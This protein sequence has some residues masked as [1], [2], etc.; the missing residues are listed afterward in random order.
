MI[1]SSCKRLIEVDM[2]IKAISKNAYEEQNVREGHLHDF[3]VWWATRPLVACRAV[4]L[5]SLLPDP[6]DESCPESFIKIAGSLLDSLHNASPGD[7]SSVRQAL[8]DFVSNFSTWHSSLDPHYLQISRALIEAAY[9]EVPVLVDPFSGSGTIPF[10]ALRVGAESFGSDLNPVATLILKNHLEDIPRYG[11]RLAESFRKWGSWIQ[12]QAKSELKEFYPQGK[13]GNVPLVYIWARTIKCEG[14]AC[15]AEVPLVGLLK[16]SERKNHPVALRY[17]VNKSKKKVEFEIFEPKS[18]KEIQEPIVKR[19]SATCPVCGYTTPYAAVVGQLRSQRGGANTARLIAVITVDNDGTRNYRSPTK[20]DL[21]TVEKAAKTLNQIRSSYQ[22]PLSLVPDESTPVTRGPGAS[23]GFSLKKYGIEKWEDMFTSRQLLALSKFVSL[24]QEAQ[25]KILDESAD[26]DFARAVS[27]CLA[28]AVSNMSQY[29]SSLSYWSADHMAK[30]FQINGIPMRPDFAEVNPLVPR[31]VGG[32]DYA[33][34]QA[35]EVI[36]RES[37]FQFLV[38][39]A[40]RASA[41]RIPLPDRSVALVVTDPPYYDAVPYSSLADFCY[42]WL[43]RAIGPLYPEIFQSK[44][45]PM[46]D[47]CILDPGIPY[48][49]GIQKDQDFFRNCISLALT[50]CRRILK[51]DGLCVV[52]FAHKATEGWEALLT[53]LVN[54]GWTVSASWPIE[55]ERGTRMRARNSA[56]LAS[57]VFL[58]CRPRAN[59]IVGEWR[60]VIRELQPRV[61]QWMSRLSLEGINGADAIFA[62][63]GPALEIFSRY[64]SVERPDGR[65][66]ELADKYDESGNV[67]ERGYLSYVWEAVGKEALGMIFQDAD[68]SGFEQDSRLTALW[69]WTLSTNKNGNRSKDIT[70][71]TGESSRGY[72]LDFDAAR[73]ISQGL[74]V[75]LEELAHPSEVV[76]IEGNAAIL[77]Y[78][79]ERRRYLFGSRTENAKKRIPDDQTTLT[80][81]PLPTE[82]I[83][84]LGQTSLDR[85]HEAMILFSDG[86]MENLRRFV[87]DQGA[88]RDPRFWRMAQALSA[89]YPRD[90]SDKRWVDGLLS[91]KK[92]FG[93]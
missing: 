50:E 81:E 90:S 69:L 23:R 1:P 85:V 53:A 78:S 87:V 56:A 26:P 32:I 91:R 42:V 84:T 40:R 57:S 82:N 3:H 76:A 39:T 68:P 54:A 52:L 29:F 60:D 92:S 74:G 61:H 70:T 66:L 89:L 5:A 21:L 88:G 46:D 28:L 37:S 15:G 63:I 48:P 6:M 44:L 36:V 13:N 83:T 4:I 19:F 17:V 59:Q 16:I 73:K 45:S 22:G 71:K 30:I 72:V 33:L 67:S 12:E 58:V 80:N 79:S 86:K 55:T 75:H 20:D 77:L 25:K 43:K 93:F 41:T 62:C 51:D 38:G 9:E 11:M 14:P 8:L 18:D 35:I 49:T 27:T 24:V 65:K 47:E 2:P 7:R 34:K 64:E 31:L 10:E